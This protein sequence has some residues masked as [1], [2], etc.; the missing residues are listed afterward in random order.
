MLCNTILCHCRHRF[1]T[2]AEYGSRGRYQGFRDHSKRNYHMPCIKYAVPQGFPDKQYFH[3][4]ASLN[5]AEFPTGPNQTSVLLSSL[6]VN[7]LWIL[8]LMACPIDRSDSSPSL[9]APFRQP[10][11]LRG[12]PSSIPLTSLATVL[13]S[14]AMPNATG[15]VTLAISCSIRASVSSAPSPVRAWPFSM[16]NAADSVSCSFCRREGLFEMFCVLMAFHCAVSTG[17]LG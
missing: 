13:N 12:P 6:P 1:A 3:T 5:P 8:R 16:Q 2:K 7:T 15:A 9:Y 10:S 17:A 4:L 14:A 11:S